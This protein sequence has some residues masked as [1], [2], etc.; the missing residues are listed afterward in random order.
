VVHPDVGTIRAA[1]RLLEQYEEIWR[2]RL[3]RIDAILT[4]P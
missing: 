3:D 4:E 1:A 2:G